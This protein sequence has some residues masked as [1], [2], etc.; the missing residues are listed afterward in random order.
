MSFKRKSWIFTKLPFS[1]H[2]FSRDAT[3]LSSWL[4]QSA[5]STQH[6]WELL[7]GNRTAVLPRHA[8]RRQIRSYPDL[9]ASKF[10]KTNLKQGAHI[11][12]PTTSS[13][14]RMRT[15]CVFFS[16]AALAWLLAT[17]PKGELSHWLHP[18][19]L[20]AQPQFFQGKRVRW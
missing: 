6:M 4:A 15:T 1:V 5:S 8:R 18:F 13:T 11:H 20:R 7:A 14:S 16:R 3:G 9:C 2:F 17:P 19:K 10:N 12:Q